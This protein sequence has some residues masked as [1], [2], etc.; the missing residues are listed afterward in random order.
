MLKQLQTYPVLQDFILS[1]VTNWTADQDI[2]P[3]QDA[4][5]E[6]NELIHTAYQYQSI[7]DFDNFIQGLLVQD[8]RLT[9]N[10]WYK[11]NN[12]AV[13]Y[14]GVRW[15]KSVMKF[16][17]EYGHELWTERYH[18]VMAAIQVSN[19]SRERE[20]AW[21]RCLE[22]K[23]T[24]W[25][26]PSSSRQL[27]TRDKKFF[28]SSTILH[29]QL[30]NHRVDTAV[31]FMNKLTPGSDIRTYGRL[32]PCRIVRSQ[33][34]NIQQINDGETNTGENI[35]IEQESE[36]DTVADLTESRL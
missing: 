15:M 26:L 19:E 31:S 20:R 33:R 25:Q 35:N 13:Q 5:S 34:Q 28:R 14:D 7:V 17:L 1:L 23:R 2:T 32:V 12:S 18:I 11:R 6:T 9:M 4:E 21:Q 24:S 10:H 29:A 36:E 22:L 8:W 3:P 30:W 16:F 27:I